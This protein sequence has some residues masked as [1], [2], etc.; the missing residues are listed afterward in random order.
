[1]VCDQ[2]FVYLISTI[3]VISGQKVDGVQGTVY[4]QKVRLNVEGSAFVRLRRDT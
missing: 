1:M 3:Y 4:S 2:G